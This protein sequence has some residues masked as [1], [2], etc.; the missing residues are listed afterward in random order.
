MTGEAFLRDFSARPSLSSGAPSLI[1][2]VVPDTSEPARL[3]E[4][5]RAILGARRIA[6]HPLHFAAPFPGPVEWV[7]ASLAGGA[8]GTM[9]V[10]SPSGPLAMH[11]L[12]KRFNAEREHLIGLK[13]PLVMVLTEDNERILRQDA[14]DFC[15][16]ASWSYAVP[17]G[18][19]PEAPL[20]SQTSALAAP[21]AP[22]ALT[23]FL[24]LSDLHLHPTAATRYDQDR[25]L[26]GLI[27]ALSSRP[28][29]EPIDLVFVTG[30]LAF[31][32]KADEYKLVVL[33]L[34]EILAATGVP[35]ERLFVI[36][37][38]HDADRATGRWL[39]RTLDS[40]KIASEFFVGEQSRRQHEQKFA[41]YREAMSTV[42]GEKRSLGLGIGEQAVET[43][44]VRGVKVAVASFNSAW[45]SQ[46][47]EDKEKLWLGEAS[48]DLAAQRIRREGD[49]ALAVA[50]MHHPTDYLADGEG[51]H[52]EDYLERSF[53][54][55]L[56]GHLHRDK[57][58]SISTPRGG[59]VEIAAGAAYQ[60]SQWPNGCFLGEV[61]S[62]E[63]TLRLTP[64]AFGRS[65]DPWALDPKVFPDA[66]ADGHRHTMA[67]PR[68]AA[69]KLSVLEELKP[70]IEASFRRLEPRASNRIIKELGLSISA[71]SKADARVTLAWEQ[72][73][74]G[75]R[76]A[77]VWDILAEQNAD[78]LENWL[79]MTAPRRGDSAIPTV[80]GIDAEA[81][82]EQLVALWRSE[83]VRWREDLHNSKLAIYAM[84]GLLTGSWSG[85]A[86]YDSGTR[87]CFYRPIGK[88]GMPSAGVGDSRDL[89]LVG[90]AWTTGAPPIAKGLDQLKNLLD[91]KAKYYVKAVAVLMIQ[92]LRPDAPP[93][94]ERTKLET[95]TVPWNDSTF[96]FW[97]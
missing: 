76:L 97:A 53:D 1:L 86:T 19:L 39:L 88:E 90:E 27:Q 84:I 61:D 96:I 62:V 37:G 11:A 92:D 7:A 20:A 23:R 82:L 57:V 17:V 58:R 34:R 48:V 41:A 29:N 72:I 67:L 47:D 56:R 79:M 69:R 3:A 16:W 4:K 70:T 77:E 25:V 87:G 26:R 46:D 59:Y 28:E 32:G 12:A 33:W 95:T 9:T 55:V 5:L 81:L 73:E 54:L 13:A 63:R 78:L 21:K 71:R 66:A 44:I 43:V 36:P 75:G 24:H 6:L 8:D 35:A 14:P 40:E 18:D 38:N 64:W 93:I 10:L 94:S 2:L 83:G 52:V 91:S 51:S 49:V 45:F 15:T 68:R 85:A 22:P 60:G 42:V 31:S 65:A 80:K 30:D 74:R 50:L 89:A